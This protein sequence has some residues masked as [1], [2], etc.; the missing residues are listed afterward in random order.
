MAINDLSLLRLFVQVVEAGTLSATARKLN[1]SLPVVSRRLRL[2]ENNLGARLLQRTTRRQSLTAEG[3]LFYQRAVQ[4]LADLEQVEQQLSRH[5]ATV[6]G[7]LRVT[8]PVALGRRRITPLLAE[9]RALHPQLHVQLELTDT[10]LDLVESGVDLAVRYGALDDSS[11]ISQPL[12]PNH[13]ILCASPDYL[14][15]HGEPR[16][17]TELVHHQC[18]QI[19]HQTQTEWRFEGDEPVTV[20]IAAT[21]VAND[22]D[23][24]HQW[25]LAGHGIARKSIWDVAEDLRVGRL[26]QVLADYPIP[27]APLHAI[28]P[29]RRHL[30]LRVRAFLDYLAAHL[31]TAA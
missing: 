11:Y 24:V 25:A 3:R 8:A 5:S 6:S 22:G 13:R 15:H 12:A 28:Y 20:K 31:G 10:V 7:H 19:G 16:H 18:L 4:I 17:P 26:V 27:A 9:F 2:L 14:Q 21:L 23:A 30:T 1:I 29:H